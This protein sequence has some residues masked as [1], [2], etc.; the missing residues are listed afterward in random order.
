M[1]TPNCNL[2]KKKNDVLMMNFQK[3][4][5]ARFETLKKIKHVTNTFNVPLTQNFFLLAQIFV[6]TKYKSQILLL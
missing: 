6:G 3:Q 5:I 4:F 1:F 2:K